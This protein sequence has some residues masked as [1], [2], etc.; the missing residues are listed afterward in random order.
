[1]KYSSQ[2]LHK[3]LSSYYR[4]RSIYYSIIVPFTGNFGAIFDRHIYNWVF[5][6]QYFAHIFNRRNNR[7]SLSSNLNKKIKAN[8]NNFFSSTH[9]ISTPTCTYTTTTLYNTGRSWSFWSR[10]KPVLLLT[11]RRYNKWS[12]DFY[13]SAD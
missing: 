5:L 6:A 13:K 2:W 12:F 3:I 4:D 7:P 8:Y 10:E 1:M 11:H 9:R